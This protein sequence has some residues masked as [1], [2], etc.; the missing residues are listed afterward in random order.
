MYI[1]D[2]STLRAGTAAAGSVPATS[3]AA[4]PSSFASGTIVVMNPGR[5]DPCTCGSGRKFKHCCLLKAAATAPE[6]LAWRRL[7]RAIDGLGRDLLREAARHFGEPGLSEAWYEFLL[8]EDDQPSFDDSPYAPVFLS[9]FVHDWLPDSTETRIPESAHAKTAAQAYL[10]RVG[11]R[12]EPL[13]RRYVEA[14]CTAPF[15]FHEV[16]VAR[17]GEG[18]RARDI[19]L[20]TELDVIEHSGSAHLSAGDILFAK[21]V[22]IEGIHVVEG[23]GPVAI[24]PVHKPALIE[25]RRKVGAQ[26]T[27]FGPER[28]RDFDIELREAY[29]DIA[30]RLLDPRLPE[31]HNTDG[32]P[33]ELHTLVFD[34]DAPEAAFEALRDLGVGLT[35]EDIESGAQRAADGSL[36]RAEI[37]WVRP[38]NA[39]NKG[40]DNT[41]LG[42]LRID[43]RRL[44]AEVNSARR[45]AALRALIEKRLGDA[46]QVR[47]S[48]VRS[49]ESMLNRPPTARE[50]ARRRQRASEQERFAALPEVQAAV[51]ETMRRH[52]R[53]WVDEEI[54]ALGNRTPRQAVRSA[55]GREAVEALIAQIERDGAHMRPPLD[56]DIVRELRETLSLTNA[57]SGEPGR[58][59]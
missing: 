49:V 33:L 51:R 8:F 10:D 23:M 28:L 3:A 21:I 15:S 58:P 13:A 9:W 11:T 57:R 50:E 18:F 48:V 38:G 4:E 31:L 43:G 16:T 35:P 14:C 29:L 52:Y 20:G 37:P 45:A 40:M 24:P 32:D 36:L 6:E 25:L 34:L 39:L 22:S 1:V 30:E 54:P 5:N 12:L 26:G 42:V 27:P 46:V 55:D 7:R 44:T 59:R 2:R 53:A 17:P 19:M 56:P 41:T 47:P